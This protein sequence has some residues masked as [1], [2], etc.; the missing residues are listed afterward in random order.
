[1]PDA[2]ARD[3]V[4][5]AGDLRA[6]IL[7]LRQRAEVRNRWLRERLE[8]YLPDLMKREGF[9]MW[10]VSAREYNE[11][12]VMMTM[13]PEPYMFARR[14][15]I[16]LFTLQKDGSVE[17]LT[18]ARYGM[19][20]FYK[21]TWDPEE[22]QYDCLAKEIKKRKPKVIGVN[23]SETFAF[24]DGLTHSEYGQLVRALGSRYSKK[25]R[26]AERLAVGWLEHRIQSELD[27]YPGIVSITHA[28]VEEAFSNRVIHPGITTTED[29]AWW[30]RQTMVDLGLQPW[31][32][33]TVDLQAL[34]QIYDQPATR[35]LI[36]P[37]DLLHC[38]VGF[39]Y[40]ARAAMKSAY[41]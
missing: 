34:G 29:V 36:K 40:L 39:Y 28:I 20:D 14:R 24:G 5:R 37:G 15:T 31:F 19:S 6:K 32:P 3:A 8:S 30:M 25:L 33:P 9:D 2:Y 22:E 4:A 11:D 13:L 17:R 10:V 7:P 21:T 1:L 12:P 35:T 27:A 38:D 26:G 41:A 23:F 16:L 18:F